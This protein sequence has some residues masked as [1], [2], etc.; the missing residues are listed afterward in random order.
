MIRFDLS[1]QHRREISDS[2]DAACQWKV[3]RTELLLAS[4]GHKSLLIVWTL[5]TQSISI[6]LNQSVKD[7]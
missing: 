6:D 1:A 3:P 5:E 4:K 7:C 2:R